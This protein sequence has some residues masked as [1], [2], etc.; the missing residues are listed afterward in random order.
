VSARTLV[1]IAILALVAALPTLGVGE[2]TI[3]PGDT[4]K[5]S[6]LGEPDQSKQAIV[7]A[8]GKIALPLIKDV[9]VAGKTTAQAASDI[10]RLLGKWLKNPDVTVEMVAK[11]KKTVTIAGQVNKPGVYPIESETRLMELVGFAGG[12]TDAADS[13]KVRITRRTGDPVSSNLQEFLSGADE[14]ANITLQEGDVVL[15][16]EKSPALGTVY[17]YGAVRQPGQAVQLREGMRASQ[18]VASAGGVVPETCDLSR[19]EIKRTEL[20]DA[21]RV[22]LAKA[23]AGD[24]GSD[25]VLKSGDVVT[26]PSRELSGTYTILGSVVRSGEYPITGNMTVSKAVA[27]A[28]TTQVSKLSD[29]RVT[30]AGEGKPQAIKVNIKDVASGKKQDV[31]LQPG[32]TVYVPEQGQKIDWMRILG[33]GLGAA[34]IFTGN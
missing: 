26:V 20:P 18:A 5:I 17:V 8:D 27:L 11:A 21:I 10:G 32:D 1:I 23:M 15:I 3:A 33:L 29:V 14:S 12:L 16:P 7:D 24:S 25:P 13:T 4:I 28:G 2:S 6:V 19:V 22:D 31:A 34:A 9:Q 30:R